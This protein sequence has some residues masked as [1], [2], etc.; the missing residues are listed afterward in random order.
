MSERGRLEEL[1][2]REAIR[3]LFSEYARLL[4]AAD[5]EGYTRLFARNGKFG[6]A[7][8]HDAIL[9]HMLA[10]GRR[11]D[12]GRAAGTFNDAIHL[13]SNFEIE[14]A[15][16][17]AK[18]GML[19]SYLSIDPD[20]AP[21]VFQLGHYRDDL[22]REDG[23]W[24]I[25]VHRISRVMG[26]GQLEPPLATRHDAL[27]AQAR[28]TADREEIRRV[29][30]DYARYL[31]SGNFEGYAS[32]FARQGYMKASLG[33]AV[34]PAEILKLL[35]KYR[36]VSKGRDFPKAVHV[37]ANHDIVIEGDNA[38]ADVLWFYLTTDPDGAPHILQGGKY[39][40]K[41]VREDGAWKLVSHD[42]DRMFGR[43][44]FEAKPE[45]RIDRLEARIRELEA[46]LTD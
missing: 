46:K 20:K 38:T 5:Y 7:E 27:A 9:A 22:V 43:A 37:T 2:D 25:L 30:T 3:Q 10:Y 11:V 6:E 39:R 13:L 14:L 16:D 44:P 33:E 31:D 36:E 41:L 35:N 1:E 23:A 12:E 15:G 42:I 21:K 29:F 24:K 8:G 45:T 19:W 26:Q 4:D 18:V 40:D 28:D 32:L 34:G 17:T